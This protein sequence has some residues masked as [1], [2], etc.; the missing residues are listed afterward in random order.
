[1]NNNPNG[2]SNGVKRVSTGIT[3]LDNVVQGGF[4][5]GRTY[6][7]TGDAGT[8]KT[9]ACMQF[10]MAGLQQDEKAV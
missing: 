6:L 3:G 1:M 8:G 7:V 4:L 9:T 2:S 5:P 10:L